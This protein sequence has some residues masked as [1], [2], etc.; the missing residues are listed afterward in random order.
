MRRLI[1][2]KSSSTGILLFAEATH[3][4]IEDDPLYIEEPRFLRFDPYA[5]R[6]QLPVVTP[7]QK[8]RY[9]LMRVLEVRVRLNRWHRH[10]SYNR[11]CSSPEIRRFSRTDMRVLRLS[12]LGRALSRK[13]MSVG[14]MIVGHYEFES[15][16]TLSSVSVSSHTGS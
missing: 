12:R 9:E 8:S 10:V 1:R 15:I 5:T 7:A 6:R 11:S 3:Q 14:V 16:H 4:A 13:Q 2:R